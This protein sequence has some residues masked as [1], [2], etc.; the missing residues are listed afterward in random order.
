MAKLQSAYRRFHSTETALLCVFNEILSAIDNKQEVLLV[1]LDLSAAFD[2][3][4]HELLLQKLQHRYGNSFELVQIV[5][6]KQNT[7]E[8]RRH[9]A[10]MLDMSGLYADLTQF[11]FSPTVQEMCIYGDAAYSLQS[12]ECVVVKRTLQIA[13]ERI[14]CVAIDEAH[15]IEEWGKDFRSAYD[16]LGEVRALLLPKLPLMALT[17]TITET[18]LAYMV[19]KLSM[20]DFTLVKGSNNRMNIFYSVSKL[21]KYQD[22]DYEKMEIAFTN[23]FQLIIQDL[24][25]NGISAERSIVFCFSHPDCCKVYEYFE[26]ELGK[27]MFHQDTKE[28]LVDIY[29]KLTSE[30]C[31]KAILKS[32]TDRAGCL[33]I[34]IASVA[35]G[36]GVNCPDVRKVIHFR[37]PASLSSYVQES[38]RAGRDNQASQAILFYSAKEFGVRKAKITK[39]ATNQNELKELEAMKEYCENTEYILSLTLRTSL[40]SRR[41]HSMLF[42]PP[43]EFTNRPHFNFKAS[44]GGKT[45]LTSAR[46]LND[47]KAY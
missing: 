46:Y 19:K 18:S 4:N 39:A 47:S 20:D 38:G 36:M 6:F 7:I 12:F 16:N 26:R 35:F 5:S 2:T 29:V 15:C 45:A 17:A 37:A 30:A 9:G 43:F 42:A 33:R 41:L 3:I 27:Q 32:F 25:E 14:H 31:K 44:C 24:K 28:R 13:K 21:E 40:S 10:R 23:C 34:I 8:G 22:N 1:M 11:A